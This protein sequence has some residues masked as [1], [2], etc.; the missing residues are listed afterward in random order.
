MELSSF[1][2]DALW[3]PKLVFLYE[4][5]KKKI[6]A[7]YQNSRSADWSTSS[8]NPKNRINTFDKHPAA[9]QID[10]ATNFGTRFFAVPHSLPAK[11]TLLR[12]DVFISDQDEIPW[13]LR[14]ALDLSR[15]V[16]LRDWDIVPTL[17]ISR[18]LSR[19]LASHCEQNPGFLNQYQ[20][21]PFGS[22]IRIE[23][24]CLHPEQADL[25]TIPA[26]DL[27]RKTRSVSYLQELWKDSVPLLSWPEVIDLSSL[28]FIKQLHDSVSVVRLGGPGQISKSSLVLKSN[29]EGVT[30]L[31]HE[32]KFLLT[33]PSHPNV[34]PK[35]LHVVTS[36]SRFGGKHGVIGFTLPYYPAKSISNLLPVRVRDR[37]WS[38]AQQVNWCRQ[39]V[40][41][42]IHIHFKTG[43]FCS[44][45]RPDNILLHKKNETDC[46]ILCDFEQRGN[47][48]EWCPPEVLYAQYVENLSMDQSSAGIVHSSWRE[49]I[50]L[51]HRVSLPAKR[52]TCEKVANSN[53]PWFVLTPEQQEKSQVYLVGLIM[54]CIFEGLSNVRI[55]LANA[56]RYEDPEVEFPIFKRTPVLVQKLIKKYTAG[57]P[58]WE[59]EGSHEGDRQLDI[60]PKRASRVARRGDKMHTEGLGGGHSISETEYDV[61]RTG[62][63]WWTTKLQRAEFFFKRH[64]DSYRDIGMIQP[65]LHEVY[66]DLENLTFN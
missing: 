37:S 57:A 6:D 39:I 1:V 18:L 9:W 34:M 28:H 4:Q 10:G 33:C 54:Y 20:Q 55:S 16:L 52:A 3:R 44:D 21:L 7:R 53:W 12:V 2:V 32:L 8:L 50:E 36:V 64:K 27:E 45:L 59:A 40:S 23:N 25:Y 56:Y 61:L 62:L 17:G 19:V 5:V 46:L 66:M 60:C 49:L 51:Y 38:S 22:K 13:S 43:L 14:Y 24:L 30:H 15:S 29:T 42:L 58:E 26:C 31:Y 35:P 48:H 11:Q 63:N 47:W 41:A 65:I